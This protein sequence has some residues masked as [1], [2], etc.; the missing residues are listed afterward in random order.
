MDLGRHALYLYTT[1]IV[2]LF[3]VTC[4]VLKAHV[5]AMVRIDL[6]T[7]LVQHDHRVIV[8]VAMDGLAE[9]V[10]SSVVPNRHHDFAVLPDES[11]VTIEGDGNNSGVGEEGCDVITIMNP[12]TRETATVF[13]VAD[14]TA[15]AAQK[16]N[17]HANAIHWWPNRG[18]YTVSVLHWNSIFAFSETGVLSWVMGGSDSDFSGASWDKQHGHHLLADSLLL[19]NNNGA[20]GDSSALEY[21]MSGATAELSFSYASS[22]NVSNTVGD[23]RRL[24]NGNTLVTYSNQGLIHE[25]SPSGQLVQSIS[26]SPVGYTVRRSTLYGPPPPYAE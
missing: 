19:F 7:V 10:F 12:G 3:G 4:K 13:T 20:D 18:L 8:R 16:D 24:P 22:G 26:T 11:I 1:P 25:V 6:D 23:A 5:V 14:A 21:Q 9:E 17:C 15:D 2:K